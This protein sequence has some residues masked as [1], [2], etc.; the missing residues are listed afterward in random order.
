MTD[1]RTMLYG[2]N[3]AIFEKAKM[4]RLSMTQYEKMLWQE[5]KS[6]K[7]SGL[8]FT[9]GEVENGLTYVIADTCNLLINRMDTTKK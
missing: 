6:N 4:L 3:P 5:L 9:N 7:I 8:R 1:R 2:A